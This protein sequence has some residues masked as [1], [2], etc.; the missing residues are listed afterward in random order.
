MKQTQAQIERREQR[1]L[2]RIRHRQLQLAIDGR[3]QESAQY[4]QWAC[5]VRRFLS[6]VGVCEFAA[7]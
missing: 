6:K 1:V 4:A 2:A 5:R 3:H 7:A